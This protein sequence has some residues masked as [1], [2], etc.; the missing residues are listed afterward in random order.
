ME[1]KPTRLRDILF[2]ALLAL[3]GIMGVCL[4]FEPNLIT[5]GCFGFGLGLNFAVWG[6]RFYFLT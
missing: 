5:S 6:H 1:E 3:Q 2:L 4:W